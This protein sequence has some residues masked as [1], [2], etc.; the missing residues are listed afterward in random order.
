MAAGAALT[1]LFAQEMPLD[2]HSSVRVN[3]RPEAPLQLV[4]V[5]SGESRALG[6]GSALELDLHM[7][8][9]L[10]NNS[11][12]TVR[13]VTLLV[14]AQEFTPG[15]RASVSLSSL[16]VGPGQTFT[17]P[18]EVKLL[19][20]TRSGGP[21]VQVNLDPHRQLASDKAASE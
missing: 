12:N 9:T 16:N 10:R 5:D 18:V 20:P 8:L 2:P 7:G 21:L 15:G 4:T 11:P 19:R 1:G 17:M 6:R 13:G 3:L 14:Q